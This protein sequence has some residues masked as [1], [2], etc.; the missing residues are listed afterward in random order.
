ML[1]LPSYLLGENQGTDPVTTEVPVIGGHAG[2]T[3]LPL[4]SQVKGKKDA[5]TQ[6]R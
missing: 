6:I 4:L 3:I 2:T 1:P 5:T